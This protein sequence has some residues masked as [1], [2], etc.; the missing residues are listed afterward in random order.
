MERL[1]VERMENVAHL[2][3]GFTR[4]VLSNHL[5]HLN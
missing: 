4:R 5:A 2:D 1:T 3:K